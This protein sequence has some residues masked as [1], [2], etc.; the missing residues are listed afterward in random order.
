[1]SKCSERTCDREATR[2]LPVR[3][4][5]PGEFCEY[6]YPEVQ[7]ELDRLRERIRL[8]ES[9][10]EQCEYRA[11]LLRAEEWERRWAETDARLQSALRA[12]RAARPRVESSV[13]RHTPRVLRM[14]DDV[15]ERET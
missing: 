10:P 3:Q 1:V 5:V 13:N 8:L 15:L 4:L 14:I 11:L 12:L 2:I 6:H 9:T 7:G